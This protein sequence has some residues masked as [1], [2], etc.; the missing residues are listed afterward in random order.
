MTEREKVVFRASALAA[1]ETGAAVSTHTYLGRNALDQIDV[2]TSQ[3]LAPD[4][5]VIGHLDDAEPDLDLIREITARGAYAQLDGIGYEYY[6]ETLGIQMTTDRVRAGAL[7]PA[8]RGRSGRPHHHGQRL[9]PET[10]SEGAGR[11]R[12]RPS[13]HR[14]P[15]AG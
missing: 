8:G 6:T 13:P 2:L 11:A 7:P 15:P 9:L 1:L 3:G 12:P 10:A 5:I 14:F 4:R